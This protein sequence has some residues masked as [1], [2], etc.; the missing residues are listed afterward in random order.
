LLDRIIDPAGLSF[1]EWVVLRLLAVHGGRSGRAEFVADLADNLKINEAAA[2]RLVDE[3]TTAG[4]VESNGDVH[5][6]EAGAA[7]YNGLWTQISE[8]SGRLYSDFDARDLEIAHRVLVEVTRR[9][10]HMLQE[11]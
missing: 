9:A 5:L 8:V 10:T 3:A 6:S 4:R 11:S 7:L 1:P 2:A